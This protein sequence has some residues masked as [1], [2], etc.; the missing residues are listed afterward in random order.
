M[1]RKSTSLVSF[2][3]FWDC[4]GFVTKYWQWYYAKGK[5]A[6]NYLKFILFLLISSTR[7]IRYDSRVD[8][9]RRIVTFDCLYSLFEELSYLVCPGQLWDSS[10]VIVDFFLL[11][12]ILDDACLTCW[13]LIFTTYDE[14]LLLWPM[15]S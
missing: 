1:F 6:T 4:N 5:W 7:L 15:S 13:F 14:I 12:I 3:I 2:K 9:G 10:K 11:I 8:N